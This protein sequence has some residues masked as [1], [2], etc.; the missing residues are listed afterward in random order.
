MTHLDTSNTSYG[1]KKSWK[2]NWQFDSRPLKVKNRSDFLVLMSHATYRWK[3]LDEGYNFV[4][5]IISIKG[6]HTKLCAPKVAKVPTLGISG[7]PLGSPRT[8][9]HLGVGPMARHKIYYK[10]EGCGFP[11]VQAMVSHMNSNLPVARPITK[12]APTMH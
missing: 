1:Q 5:N 10:G 4:L 7:L 8:K 11:Q 3:A 9:C 2:S 12:N 6:L